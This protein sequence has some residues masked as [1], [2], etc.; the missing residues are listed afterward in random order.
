MSVADSLRI[1]NGIL[2]TSQSA[3][4]TLNVEVTALQTQLSSTNQN[5][6]A[7]A[8]QNFSSTLQSVSSQ[9]VNNTITIQNS[10][11]TLQTGG[12]SNPVQ[13]KLNL[14]GGTNVTLVNSGGDVTISIPIVTSAIQFLIDGGGAVP[15]TGVWGQI[16]LPYACTIKSWTLTSDV[17]GSAVIDLLRSTYAGFPTMASIAGTD[18]PTLVT[19]QKNTDSTLTG[20]GS[21]ALNAGD[22]L[23][24]NLNSVTTCQRLNLTVKITVP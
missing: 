23:Q 20:W 17:T 14:I 22:E 3:I 5:D 24:I 13:N 12:V 11:V 18:K 15:A 4:N 8:L 6:I 9:T 21:T 10:L 16:S 1:L 2:Q 19:A 7:Q